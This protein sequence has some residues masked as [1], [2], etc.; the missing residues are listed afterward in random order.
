MQ[1][2]NFDE[3]RQTWHN[4]FCT[5]ICLRTASASKMK[6][7]KKLIFGFIDREKP[8]TWIIAIIISMLVVPLVVTFALYYGMQ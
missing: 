3:Q 5:I 7:K 6:D 8:M 4:L 2:H 1:K